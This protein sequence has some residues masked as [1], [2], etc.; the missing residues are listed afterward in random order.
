MSSTLVRVSSSSELPA[1]PRLPS[2]SGPAGRRAPRQRALS[3]EAIAT[4]A[5]EIVDRDGLDALTMRAVADA[6][7]T[8]AASLYAH[9]AS[10]EELLELVVERVIGEIPTPRDLDPERWQEHVK[11]WG[12]AVRTVYSRHRDV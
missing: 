5:L 7:A 8:G 6:L 2:R 1:V 11:E 3:R 9:V 12:R 4:A 10:K